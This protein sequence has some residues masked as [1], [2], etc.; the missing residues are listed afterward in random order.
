MR[1][2]RLTQIIEDPTHLY[3]ITEYASGGELFEYIV[4]NKR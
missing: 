2:S 1:L 4:K 3:L